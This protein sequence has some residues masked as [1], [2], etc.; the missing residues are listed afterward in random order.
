[1]TVLIQ[2]MTLPAHE[3]VIGLQSPYLASAIQEAL[4]TTGN[5]TLVFNEGSGIAHWRV[6]EYLYTGGY[7]DCSDGSSPDGK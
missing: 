2:T 4:A 6:F 7:T 3:I 1:M 5:R